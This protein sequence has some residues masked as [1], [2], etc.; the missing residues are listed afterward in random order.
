MNIIFNDMTPNLPGAGPRENCGPQPP[1]LDATQ[2]KGLKAVSDQGVKVYMNDQMNPDSS[3]NPDCYTFV[4][5]KTGSSRSFSTPASFDHGV[6]SIVLVTDENS[7]LTLTA[8]VTCNSQCACEDTLSIHNS[9]LQLYPVRACLSA[10]AP[11]NETHLVATSAPGSFLV[12]E[13]TRML[14]SLAS[15]DVEVQSS[16][17]SSLVPPHDTLVKDDNSN[18]LNFTCYRPQGYAPSCSATNMTL[19][20]PD[21]IM[22]GPNIA[23]TDDTLAHNTTMADDFDNTTE[24]PIASVNITV[25]TVTNNDDNNKYTTAIIIDTGKTIN[26]SIKTDDNTPSYNNVT[27][28]NNANNSHANISNITTNNGNETIDS[29]SNNNNSSDNNNNNTN[30]N[31]SN[32][33]DQTLNNG[34]K[35]NFCIHKNASNNNNNNNSTNNNNNLNNN[36]NNNSSGNSNN[37][38]NNQTANIHTNDNTAKKKIS[39]GTSSTLSP[40]IIAGIAVACLLA[41]LLVGVLTY[42]ALWRQKS[43]KVQPGFPGASEHVMGSPAPTSTTVRVVPRTTTEI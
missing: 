12:L 35:N 10:H 29:R 39:G 42:F 25:N 41:L 33:C 15:Y 20:P 43:R 23:T 7:T 1:T 36:S 37:N 13:L 27:G 5:I 31:I 34:S 9:L 24:A 11:V 18:S 2:L 19:T 4:Y 3:I 8:D 14:D 30:K 26:S 17:D 16:P 21:I 32:N 38:N 22:P 28:I 6:C 40:G